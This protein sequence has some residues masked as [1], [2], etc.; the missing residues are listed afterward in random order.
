MKITHLFFLL[1]LITACQRKN[2]ITNTA[3]AIDLQETSDSLSLFG[4]NVISTPLY[5]RDIAINP[6]GDEIIY[7]L[8]NYSQRLRCLVIMHKENGSWSDPEIMSISGTWQDIE[9]FYTTDGNS[10]F[11]ASNRPVFNDSSRQDYNIWFSNRTE[12]GWSQPQPLDTIINTKADEFYPS[13]SSNG[14]L[15]FTATRDNGKGKEDIFVSEYK[16]GSYNPPE[17]LPAAINT[18]HYEFNAYI[19][20]GEDFIV[21]SSYGRND[22]LGGG[23]I[24]ISR[25]DKTGQWQ[26]AKNPGNIINSP[27]LDYCPF[28][29]WKNRNLYITSERIPNKQ[30]KR[31]SVQ[32]IKASSTSILNGFGN[33]Y[34]IS[35]DKLEQ[36]K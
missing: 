17:P 16:N 28:I 7:T 14:N 1:L 15:Y 9:P 6:Q 4:R 31:A 3:A 11:F 5:E 20:P 23:D 18:G 24:Y 22:G 19:S 10:L 12:N 8:G 35:L 29:E 2:T 21:F 33:I 27:Y 30:Q 34:R 13:L 36:K 25:K 32:S 26:K